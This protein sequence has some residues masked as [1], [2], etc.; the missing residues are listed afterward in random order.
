MA[1]DLGKAMESLWPTEG[2][3]EHTNVHRSENGKSLEETLFNG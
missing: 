1:L 3:Q 2:F